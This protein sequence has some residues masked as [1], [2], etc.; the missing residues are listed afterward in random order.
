M[1]DRVICRSKELALSIYS[2]T[3]SI[4]REALS[5]KI[6]QRKPALDCERLLTRISKQ[7]FTAGTVTGAKRPSGALP[8]DLVCTIDLHA[9]PPD[10]LDLRH[11]DRIALGPITA[12]VRI[13]A[14]G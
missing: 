10:L 1:A 2:T 8:P 11:Q 7:G 6:R 4:A 9:G 14:V 5:Y 3:G 13:A 12:L